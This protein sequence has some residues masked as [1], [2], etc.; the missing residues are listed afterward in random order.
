MADN[1][2]FFSISITPDDRWPGNAF[3]HISSI[4]I[5]NFEVIQT[6]GTNEGPRSPGAPLAYAGPDQTI[7]LGTMADLQGFV[8]FT[9]APPV[10][11]WKLYSGPGSVTFG[12]AAQTNSTASFGT[13]GVHTL[14]L[15]ADDGVHA[16]AYDAVVMT[17]SQAITVA[18]TRTGTNVNLTWAGGAPPYTLEKAD[19]LPASSWMTVVATK[20]NKMP[21]P[22][23]IRR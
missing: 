3:S 19:A 4:G 8:S 12:N 23:S 11:Q 5:T 21:K 6:T 14:M 20:Y 13:N 16:I 15:S 18:I 2:S 17:V 9:G 22:L 10:I 1:G 7:S